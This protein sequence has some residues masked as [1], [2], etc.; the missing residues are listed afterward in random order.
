[1]QTLTAD[2]IINAW[3]GQDN[4]IS[5]ELEDMLDLETPVIIKCLNNLVV[6]GRWAV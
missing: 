5:A 6:C 3:V 2:E 1:M 4:A